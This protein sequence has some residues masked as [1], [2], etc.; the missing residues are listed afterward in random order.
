MHDMVCTYSNA[1]HI[2]NRYNNHREAFGNKVKVNFIH[3]LKLFIT[4]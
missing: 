2:V 3:I 1:W 4:H